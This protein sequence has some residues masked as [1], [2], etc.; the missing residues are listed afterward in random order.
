MSVDYAF[1]QA[2]GWG[3][4]YCLIIIGI[5]VDW[6]IGDPKWLPHPVVAMGK[7]IHFLDKRLNKGKQKK[8]KGFLL[9][10]C[11]LLITFILV[12]GIQTLLLKVNFGLFLLFNF[13]LV[14]TSLAERTLGNEVKKVWQALLQKD[15][16]KARIQLSY[17][18]GRDT[19]NLNENEII[20]GTVETTA[21]NTID[22][23]LAPLFFLFLGI[24]MPVDWLNPVVLVMLYKGTNTLDSMVGYIQEP[25]KEFGFASAKLDDIL[26]FIP[27][28]IGSIFMVF[29]GMFLGFD[30]KDGF[31]ILK[32]D[33]KNHKSP[34]SGHPE[35]AVAGLLG[36]RLGGANHYFGEVMEKPS[37]GDAKNDLFPQDIRDTISIMFESEILVI[38]VSV[39]IVMIVLLF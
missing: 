28:R 1:P 21:E 27:A 13:Y 9:V 26:N 18:V 33:R 35:S 8:E 15:I 14:L 7:L 19:E 34:N 17:L 31:R 38:L 23:V 24:F 12:Y 20:R 3:Y 39:A 36:I 6:I 5:F 10:F 30:G 16:P 22:G 37:I 4:W 32:R 29:A 25:Y 11:V 2:I